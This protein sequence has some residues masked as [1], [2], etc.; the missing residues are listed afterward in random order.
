MTSRRR[1]TLPPSGR[2]GVT[3]IEILVAMTIFLIGAAGIIGL[4]SAG[5]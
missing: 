4:M 2:L 5:G 1:S 3:L